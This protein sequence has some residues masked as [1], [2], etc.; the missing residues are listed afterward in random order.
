MVGLG[1]CVR[2]VSDMAKECID[3]G[4]T[5]ELYPFGHG[6]WICAGCS[7]VRD[8]HDSYDNP[9]DIEYEDYAEENF[10]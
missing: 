6:A 2:L 3:C 1:T 10:R 8:V 4:K 5:Y 7:V 9:V